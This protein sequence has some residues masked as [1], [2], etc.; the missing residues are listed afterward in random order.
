MSLPGGPGMR[1]GHVISRVDGTASRGQPDGRRSRN[2]RKCRADSFRR[3]HY[4]AGRDIF[5]RFVQPNGYSIILFLLVLAQII[6]TILAVARRKELESEFAST[7]LHQVRIRYN[8]SAVRDVNRTDFLTFAWDAMQV[9]LSCCG[10]EGPGDY[11]FSTWWNHTKNS[12][13]M[14]I[15][16]TCCELYNDNPEV[17]MVRDNNQCQIE[18]FIYKQWKERPEEVGPMEELHTKGCVEAV[19]EWIDEHS[20]IIVTC[21]VISTVLQALGVFTSCFLIFLLKREHGKDWT[22]DEE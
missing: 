20:D 3:R 18:G 11:M 2:Q 19:L 10:A 22:D 6:V 4:A 21:I 14:A 7:M 13:G 9:E 15:P 5:P 1:G 16:H 17:P 12:A 8:R